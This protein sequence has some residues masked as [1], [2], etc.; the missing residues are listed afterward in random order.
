MR[1]LSDER[2]YDACRH[3]VIRNRRIAGL[4]GR[5]LM[6]GYYDPNDA[7]VDPETLQ[8]GL[9]DAYSPRWNHRH[10]ADEVVSWFRREGFREVTVVDPGTGNVRVRGQRSM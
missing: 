2:R 6:V 9:F 5:F 4:V 3:L 8:F 7:T 1:R 10:R